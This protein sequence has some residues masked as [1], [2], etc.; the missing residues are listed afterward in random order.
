ME[1]R[2][3]CFVCGNCKRELP[4]RCLAGVVQ[5]DD[6]FRNAELWCHKCAD[7]DAILDDNNIYHKK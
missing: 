3:G 6:D 4:D 2:A 7:K 1:A 5:V